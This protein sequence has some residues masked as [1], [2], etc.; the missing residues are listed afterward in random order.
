MHLCT[1][2]LRNASSSE[3]QLTP[4]SVGHHCPSEWFNGTGGQWHIG[5]LEEATPAAGG[6]LRQG[7][8]TGNARGCRPT[9]A[10]CT[11]KPAPKR[12][13]RLRAC[14]VPHWG[15][16]P[17]GHEWDDWK[18]VLALYRKALVACTAKL[19]H[20]VTVAPHRNVSQ[21]KTSQVQGRR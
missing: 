14:P 16:Q 2:R 4:L 13:C 5:P 21:R 3:V 17:V 11:R 20:I 10:A 19:P 8:A 7:R 18:H 12:A 15:L 6:R 9:R 1:K